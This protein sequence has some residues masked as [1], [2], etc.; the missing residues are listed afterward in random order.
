MKQARKRLLKPDGN[1]AA[2]EKRAS[3]SPAAPAQKR[4]KVVGHAGLSAE[5]KSRVGQP[6]Q[7]NPADSQG[8]SSVAASKNAAR[9]IS[10]AQIYKDLKYS[11]DEQDPRFDQMVDDVYEGKMSLPDAI[12]QFLD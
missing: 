8:L 4:Q 12:R 1:G 11:C 6:L 9:K 2:A 10:R 7:K 3:K 5:A